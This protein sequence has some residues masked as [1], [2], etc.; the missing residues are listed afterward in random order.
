MFTNDARPNMINLKRKL[1]LVTRFSLLGTKLKVLGSLQSQMLLGFTF[2]TFQTQNNLPRSLGLL[3]KHGLGLSTESHLFGIV[4]TLTLGEVGSLTGRVLG[5]LMGLVL[6]AFFA[7]AVGLAFFGYVDH[8][9]YSG[10]FFTDL[11]FWVLQRNWL[12]SSTKQM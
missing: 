4:T 6:T 5:H 1:I 3:V 10:C 9:D 7:G 11:L 2:L 12:S 8:F